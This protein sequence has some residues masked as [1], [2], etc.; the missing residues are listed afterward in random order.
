MHSLDWRPTVWV[1][2]ISHHQFWSWRCAHLTGALQAGGLQ[3]AGLQSRAIDFGAGD[4]LTG[5]GA[6]SLEA[7]R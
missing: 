7:D 6:Y 1:P 4:A 5:L 2:T 3:S